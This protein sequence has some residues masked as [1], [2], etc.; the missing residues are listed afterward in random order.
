[1]NHL[2][3]ISVMKTFKVYLKEIYYL[4]YYLIA[5]AAVVIV[6][7]S[8]F[9][10]LDK[11]SLVALGR[12]DSIYEWLAALL[13]LAGS[14]L[15]F[16][17]FRR[18]RNYY[19]LLFSIAL[20][21]GAG[22]EIS[23]G[24]RI[25]GFETPPLIAKINVQKECTLHNLDIFSHFDSQGHEKRGLSR[26][27]GINFLFRIFTMFLGIVVPFCVYHS[28]AIMKITV[29]I[30][31]PVVPITIGSFFLLSWFIF[32]VLHTSII[33]EDEQRTASEIFEHVASFILLMVS[34]YFFRERKTLT[35][36][37]DIKDRLV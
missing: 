11:D 26:L 36:G 2:D 9:F 30:K 29:K 7:Y 27:L 23:W 17:T 25:I 19:F 21:L 33:P 4:R 22:E 10:V 20:L 31:L 8:V 28:K 13:F 37:I 3:I 12:E 5:I 16:I 18:T 15:S 34:L 35:M 14:V 24:Q 6:S 32:R 1:M